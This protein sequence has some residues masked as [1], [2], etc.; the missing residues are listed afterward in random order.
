MNRD[1]FLPAHQHILCIVKAVKKI[2]SL[3]LSISPSCVSLSLT[4]KFIVWPDI[5]LNSQRWGRKQMCRRKSVYK[6]AVL[7]L[8]PACQPSLNISPPSFILALIY[9]RGASL[10]RKEEGGTSSWKKKLSCSSLPD[11]IC[12]THHS[13]AW[14]WPNPSQ[15]LSQPKPAKQ[16]WFCT[17]V[18]SVLKTNKL[19]S[20]WQAKHRRIHKEGHLTFK[21]KHRYHWERMQ[22]KGRGRWL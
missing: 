13:W 5:P 4:A 8:S 12:W 14:V 2:I 18:Q 1:C 6:E 3:P 11:I 7:Q 21:I 16:V 15:V 17:W 19:T 9:P 10:N 22:E 20:N